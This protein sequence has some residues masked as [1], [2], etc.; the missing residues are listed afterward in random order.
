MGITVYSHLARAL[1]RARARA[2]PPNHIYDQSMECHDTHGL[3]GMNHVNNSYGKR[4]AEQHKFETMFNKALLKYLTT[5]N[6]SWLVQSMHNG[7]GVI[8]SKIHS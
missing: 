8:L 4:V 7:S 3:S 5:L 2:R 6:Q 1:A